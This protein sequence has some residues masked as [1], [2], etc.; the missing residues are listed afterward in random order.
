MANRPCCIDVYQ[1]DDVSDDPTALAGFDK[2][3]ASGIFALIHKVSEG[4]TE[5]DS[6]YNARR[7]KW[8]DGEAIEVTDLDGSKFS[9]LPLFGGYH[10]FYGANPAAEAKHFLSVASFKPG[11]LPFIDW[12]AGPS[13]H[14]PS[15]EAADTFCQAVEQALGRVCGVYGGNVPRER[16]I[17]ER[18]S[19]AVLER[20]AS[21]PFWFCAY[22]SY[23]PATF[24]TLIPSAWQDTGVFLWQD[25]G[26]NAG[27]GPHR[28]P[29]INNYCDN[30]T[31]VE[32]QTFKGLTDLWAKLAGGQ[33]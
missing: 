1:G 8:C 14:Q 12:E 30:S 22:G 19:E 3:K 18:P 25:D 24:Q 27:P 23:T 4:T 21:R 31:V 29:G 28:I 32:D 17:A 15:L 10:F 20:F 5:V 6:R 9:T 11:D 33:S 26:D 16:M 13:G 7:A 2:A